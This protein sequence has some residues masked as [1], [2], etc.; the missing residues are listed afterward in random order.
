LLS[1]RS[2]AAAA[3]TVL[4]GVLTGTPWARAADEAPP[5]KEK[6]VDAIGVP[7]LS[8]N[9][10]LGVGI[11]AV[12]GSYV[13]SPGYR[14]YR[15][16]IAVQ[17]FFTTLGV[18][19]HWLRYDGPRLL[20]SARVEARI[21][22]KRELYS[23]YYGPGN[24]S[25]PQFEGNL[26]DRQFHFDKLAPAAWVRLRTKPLGEDSSFQPYV[27]YGYRYTRVSTYDESLLTRERPR[28]AE[29]GPT[30]QAVFGLLWDTRDDESDTTRGGA[31]EISFRLA[32]DPTGSAYDYVGVTVSERRFFQ[33]GSPR[34]VL[35]L[36]GAV[37]VLTGDVPF[38]EWSSIGG[39]AGG[40][41]IGGMSS[42]RGV[43]RNRYG[44]NYKAYVNSELR[45][46]PWEFPLWGQPVKV[47]GLAFVDLGRVWHPGTENGRWNDW[48]PGAGAG[49]RL[50]RRAAVIRVDYGVA[51]EDWRQGL[52]VTF[53]HMF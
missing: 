8:Y 42:V 15:H 21:E 36:R 39:L 40:E 49:L 27:G 44:G 30:G 33:L 19:N 38:F 32:A 28:G 13:Y 1:M 22:Y 53:G 3:L 7:L 10:D 29:G 52:Y 11:G 2:T 6:G 14:P 4:V 17:A 18:Q 46:Y 45:F 41:G 25:S 34:L 12:G 20:G 24:L 23:P 51:L 48:H 9:S 37:D 5:R 47:G 43:F 35:G 16:G 26:Q 50:A 31:E